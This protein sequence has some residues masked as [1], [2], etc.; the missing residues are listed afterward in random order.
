MTAEG[1]PPLRLAAPREHATDREVA[2]SAT[3]AMLA[4]S[5]RLNSVDTDLLDLTAHVH[6]LTADV[7]RVLE[8][9]SINRLPPM[10]P[11]S[12]SSH[13]LAEHAA[14]ELGRQARRDVDSDPRRNSISPERV[15]ELATGV[16]AEALDK[17]KDAEKLKSAEAIIAAKAKADEE[18]ADAVRDYKKQVRV[19]ITML[20][21]ATAVGLLVAHE[22]GVS[23]GKA[24]VVAPA[25]P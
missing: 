1:R 12:D 3:N 21:I 7:R 23:S 2:V 10:R 19:G 9:A 20:L 14:Q 5:E 4:L 6:V 22:Q 8:G 11:E 25:H 24:Q 16:I 15:K 18:K 13:N 17:A